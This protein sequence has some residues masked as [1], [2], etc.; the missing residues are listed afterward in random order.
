MKF[1]L[2]APS[3][4]DAEAA[5]SVAVAPPIVAV[6]LLN[7]TV[8]ES[9]TATPSVARLSC[10]LPIVCAAPLSVIVASPMMACVIVL[11]WTSC[12]ISIAVTTEPPD[13]VMTAIMPVRVAVG[14][15]V[16]EAWAGAV[17]E[18]A[19]VTPLQDMMQVFMV[20]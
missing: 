3:L 6:V 7:I 11:P 2:A 1:L 4:V 14:P 15:E 18:T 9:P 12:S 20:L 8:V 19:A 13:M 10:A 16:E 5:E 17:W